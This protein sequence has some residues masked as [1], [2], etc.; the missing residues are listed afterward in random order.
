MLKEGTDYTAVYKNNKNTGKAKVILTGKGD[1]QGTRTVFFRIVPKK[2]TSVKAVHLGN[3]TVRVT[4]KRDKKA[5]GYQIQYSLKKSFK[6]G[7]G[8]V[9]V[10]KNRIT[11]KNLR[12]LK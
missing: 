4:W 5:S 3:R 9:A 8:K 10:K 1:Y 11:S 6:K 2:A 12:N 7:V